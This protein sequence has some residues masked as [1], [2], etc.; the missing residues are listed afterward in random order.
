MA[1]DNIHRTPNGK[2]WKASYYR[3]DGRE[4]SK[5]FD[6]YD[7]AKK[8]KAANE[9]AKDR[10]TWTDPDDALITL[11]SY[12]YQR[13]AGRYYRAGPR[14]K[15]QWIARYV[16]RSPLGQMPLVKIRTSHVQQWVK[17]LGSA[18]GIRVDTLAPRTVHT[19]RKELT[20]IFNTAVEDGLIERSPV[21]RHLSMP[22]LDETPVVPLTTAQVRRLAAAMPAPDLRTMVLV[23]A[24]LGLRLGELCGLRREDVDFLRRTVRVDW[25]IVEVDRRPSLGLGGDGG[26]LGQQV[27]RI[28]PKQNSRRTLDA[29]Q[30]VLD[31]LAAH[32][33]A[34]PPLPDDTPDLGGLIFYNSR[35]NHSRRRYSAAIGEV[36]GADPTFPPGTHSHDLRHY[37]ASVMLAKGYSDLEVAAMLGHFNKRG[38][39]NPTEVHRT[40]GHL[41]PDRQRRTRHGIDEAF[42]E[43][44]NDDRGVS[45]ADVE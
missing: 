1:G 40:Y 23:Q 11:A 29:P 41:M 27:G 24:G 33:A 26:Q 37:F 35:R 16:E 4:E 8:W 45:D 15:E 2:R 6:R 20:A 43:A 7:Q 5:V 21:S 34:Y 9:R 19:A 14:H 25:Q 30:A 38:K 28:S 39:P 17:W 36:V 18:A 44:S 3:P 13:A 42:G 32:M 10:G 22:K 31:A 12:A